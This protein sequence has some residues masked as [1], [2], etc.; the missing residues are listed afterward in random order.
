MVY[1]NPGG[2]NWGPIIFDDVAKAYV[3]IIALWTA[4]ITSGVYG[5]WHNRKLPFIRMRNP[6]L[7]GCSVGALQIYLVMV[8]IVYPLNGTFTCSA[9]YWIMTL[10]LP[11]GIALFQLQNTVLLSRS[12]LQEDMVWTEHEHTATR[13]RAL[14]DKTGLAYL[15]ERF[16]QMTAFMKTRTLIVVGLVVQVTTLWSNAAI[17]PRKV[18]RGNHLLGLHSLSSRSLFTLSRASSTLMG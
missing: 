16:K 17:S 7:L 12:L 6:F 10:Y 5:I 1:I 13:A 2:H 14:R 8:F 9:E 15:I 18:L 4:F 3:A 11:I